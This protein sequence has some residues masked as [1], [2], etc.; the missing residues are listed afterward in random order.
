MKKFDPAT[1]SVPAG[2]SST[3]FIGDILVALDFA[4]RD[5]VDVALAIQ[6]HER[7]SL[8]PEQIAANK[9]ARFTGEILVDTG[10]CTQDQIDYA[11]ELQNY[12][13]K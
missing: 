11:M 7:D 3:S 12:L 5:Q 10:V 13:R 1:D 2:L 8:T 9:K 6:K 4:T